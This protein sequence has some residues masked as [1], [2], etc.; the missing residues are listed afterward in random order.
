MSGDLLPVFLACLETDTCLI[1]SGEIGAGKT[2]VAGHLVAELDEQRVAVG[3]ILSP[4]IIEAGDTIGYTIRDLMTDEER[5]FASLDPPGVSVGKFFIAEQ[6]LAFARCAIEQATTS[7]HTVFV[8]EVGMLELAGNGLAPALRALL[9]SQ[10]LPVLL[11]RPSFVEA[12]VSTF[13]I[14]RFREFNVGQKDALLYS[15]RRVQD[16]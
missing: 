6:G 13:S 3:G 9:Q 5:P 16:T 1:L 7:T 15:E 14:T 8:D 11:V 12:V 10:I 2:S 4:R